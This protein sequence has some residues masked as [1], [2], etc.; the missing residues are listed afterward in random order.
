MK[1]QIKLNQKENQAG[2]T[3][4]ELS[5]VLVLIGLIVTG[6]L[7]GQSLIQQGRLQKQITQLKDLDIAI[8]AFRSKYNGLPGDTPRATRYFGETSWDGINE[9]KNGDG[10]GVLEG[11]VHLEGEASQ[12]FLHLYQ[13]ELVGD[14][15]SINSVLPTV[16]DRG[17][18]TIFSERKRN[19][20]GLGVAA[21]FQE[22]NETYIS[23]DGT[24]GDGLSGFESQFVDDKIDDGLPLSGSVRVIQGGYREIKD[25]IGEPSPVTNE[26]CLTD[27]AGNLVQYVINEDTTGTEA[28]CPIRIRLGL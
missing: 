1:T 2:F 5:I 23:D 15:S 8:S 14:A 22:E 21:S 11:D 17:G 25:G 7:Y 9:V 16:L 6:V 13:S 12:T 28:N 18:L 4:V 27:E 20:Y 10:D 3:L 26:L 24:W 19:Y